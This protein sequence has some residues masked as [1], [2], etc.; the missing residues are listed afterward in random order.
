MDKSKDRPLVA[1]GLKDEIAFVM[2]APR[3]LLPWL[4]ELFA[5]LPD[6][7]GATSDVLALLH[8]FNL[9]RGASVL[10]LGCGRGEIAVAVAEAFE[11]LKKV[12]LIE[13]RDAERV[14]VH[15]AAK[16]QAELDE[17]GINMSMAGER[18]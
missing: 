14:R 18:H 15:E 12:E 17:I 10:D 7:S 6:L 13:E 9:P 1:D 5:D 16:E 2:E 8:Q 3:A 4:P 11:E